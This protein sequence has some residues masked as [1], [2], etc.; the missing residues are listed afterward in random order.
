MRRVVVTGMGLLSP[1]GVGVDHAWKEL[2]AGKSAARRIDAV[3][4]DDLPRKIAN[5]IPRDGSE[6]AFDPDRFMEPKGQRKLGEYIIYGIAAADMALE[7]AG[8]QPE[9]AEDQNAT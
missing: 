5:I 6:P 9:T 1:L 2:L 3:L 7:D 8:W 4:V